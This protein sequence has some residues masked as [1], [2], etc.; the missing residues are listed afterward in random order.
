M[1]HWIA[2]VALSIAGWLSVS[3]PAQAAID[4]YEF[5]SPEQE[6]AFQD[7]TATLRCPKCQNNNIADSNAELAKDMRQKVFELLNQ[8]KSKQEI[9]DYMIARYGNFV[10][11]NPPIMPSTLILWLGP[12]CFLLIGACVL[13]YRSRRG[14]TGTKTIDAEESA[15]LNALLEEIGQQADKNDQAGESKVKK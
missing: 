6:V 5:K 1:K 7:L 10:T 3:L 14:V 8:G 9:I 4:V 11:Y 2:V 15:R 12:L 13:V